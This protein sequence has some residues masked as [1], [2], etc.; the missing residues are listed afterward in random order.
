LIILFKKKGKTGCYWLATSKKPF[1]CR[2]QEGIARTILAL[3]ILPAKI[4]PKR[5]GTIKP[6][7]H[8]HP[9][10]SWCPWHA[11]KT[12]ETIQKFLVS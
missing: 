11:T 6:L 5:M 2:T 12:A 10:L 4:M 7:L 8:C 9:L 1:G 3:N